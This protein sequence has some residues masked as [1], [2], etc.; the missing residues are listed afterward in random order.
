MDFFMLDAGTSTVSCLALFALRIRVS[1]SAMGSV[2]CMSL[3]SYLDYRPGPVQTVRYRGVGA[4]PTC[5][6]SLRL[7]GAGADLSKPRCSG[8]DQTGMSGF[9]PS[10]GARPPRRSPS[11]GGLGVLRGTPG[12][13]STFKQ[14]CVILRRTT[15][16]AEP[17]ELSPQV[18]CDAIDLLYPSYFEISSPFCFRTHESV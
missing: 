16:H 2:I 14:R 18:P 4:S 13:F 11:L 3:T 8:F 6:P 7:V 15:A 9:R 12:R 17:L 10:D 1:I 5:C